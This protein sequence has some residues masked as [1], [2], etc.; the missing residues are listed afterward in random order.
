VR[1]PALLGVALLALVS[2]SEDKGP[3]AAARLD[4]C[5]VLRPGD[6]TTAAGSRLTRSEPDAQSP[7]ARC[8]YVLAKGQVNVTVEH[9]QGRSF[10]AAAGRI[11]DAAKWV[12]KSQ[13]LA[14]HRGNRYVAVQVVSTEPEP[15]RRKTAAALART[16]LTRMR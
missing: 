13:L 15:T 12:P 3:P 6:F 4:P 9:D 11:G 10:F 14:A 8:F 16:A 5:A 1:R 7:G 2:C